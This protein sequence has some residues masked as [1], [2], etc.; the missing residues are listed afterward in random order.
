MALL[1][2]IAALALFATIARDLVHQQALAQVDLGVNRWIRSRATLAGY[3]FW[4]VVSTVGDGPAILV[5]GSG[6]AALLLLRK[7][8]LLLA[9][10][11]A[12]L[13]GGMALNGAL[14]L[15]FHR[16][17]PETQT[18]FLESF[19]WSF[20]SGHAFESL[21]AYGMLAYL[22]VVEFE[23]QRPLR[24]VVIG[25]CWAIVIAIGISRLYLGVHY[26]SD[27]LGGFAVGGAW[28]STCILALEAVRRRG[29]AARPT[30]LRKR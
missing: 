11:A 27:V 8:F 29:T 30:P 9:G 6:V 15:A 28:L 26:F 5:L 13:L 22:I 16:P 17:R 4:S 25:A 2:S 7:R 24:A 21:I 14:K 10:W 20:P 3:G 18:D 1:V 12:A 23:M 19:S